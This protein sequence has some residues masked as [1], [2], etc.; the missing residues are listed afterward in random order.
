MET[1]RFSRMLFAVSKEEIYSPSIV[2]LFL[3]LTVCDCVKRVIV[4]LLAL[5]SFIYYKIVQ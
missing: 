2:C 4:L 5:V 3:S 1:G